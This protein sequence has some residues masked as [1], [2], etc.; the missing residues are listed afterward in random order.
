MIGP[1]QRTGQKYT[2][3]PVLANALVCM[4]FVKSV[5][6][7]VLSLVPFLT[8]RKSLVSSHDSDSYPIVTQYL[9]VFRRI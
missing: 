5:K 7:Q 1:Y 4:T 3:T 9:E 8:F 6:T 2:F